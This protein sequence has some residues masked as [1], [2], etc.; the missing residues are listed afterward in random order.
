MKCSIRK[1]R[2]EN[3][4]LFDYTLNNYAL[5]IKKISLKV[6]ELKRFLVQVGKTNNTILQFH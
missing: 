5:K 6:I 2:I 4:G 1:N 3:I